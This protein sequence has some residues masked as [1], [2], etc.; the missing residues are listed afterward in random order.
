MHR[1]I[2]KSSLAIIATVLIAASAHAQRERGDW[3]LYYDAERQR[4]QISFEDFDSRDW[5]TST[6]L[7][8][9]SRTLEGVTIAQIE[10]PS[11]SVRFRLRRDAGTFN[12][13]GSV[14]S[15]R[16]RGTFDFTA[17]PSFRDELAR[18]GYSRPSD[19]QQFQLAMHDVGFT[20]IDELRTQGYN[21]SST[22]DLVRMGQHGVNYDFVH[23]LASFGYKLRDTDDL[24]EFRDHGVTPAYINALRDAGYTRLA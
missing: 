20:F 13:E 5:Q 9:T 12:F 19:E 21:R 6:A 4:V 2:L 8:A 14:G 1:A 3:K 22:G 16:G 11:S 10:G 24:V 7:P 18:R 23:G 15:G 17:N